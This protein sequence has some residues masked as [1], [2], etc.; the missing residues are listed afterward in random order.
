MSA[1]LSGFDEL[2][3]AMERLRRVGANPVKALK[4]CSEHI[5][6]DVSR[7]FDAE[8][9]PDGK[10]DPLAPATIARRRKAGSMSPKILQDKAI[11]KRSFQRTITNVLDSARV[12]V[13][14]NDQRAKFHQDPTEVPT[15]RTHIP[16]RAM[17][18]FDDDLI[19]KCTGEFDAMVQEALQ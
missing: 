12:E 18:G 7:N 9:G 15:V 4:R 8:A 13:G 5:L 11:L 10:W 17:I 6:N 19:D 3:A 16:E 2:G 1:N 14:T